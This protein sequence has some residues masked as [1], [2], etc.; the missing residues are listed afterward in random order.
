MPLTSINFKYFILSLEYV[1]KSVLFLFWILSSF[2]S[3]IYLIKV[4]FPTPFLPTNK[5]FKEFI[6]YLSSSFAIDSISLIILAL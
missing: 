2:K 5:I 3:R 6:L 4:V 1:L